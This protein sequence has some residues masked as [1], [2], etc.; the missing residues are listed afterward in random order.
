MEEVSMMMI[1]LP[2]FM[3]LVEVAHI[4]PILFGLLSLINME[5][6][7]LSPPFGFVLFT[8]KGVAPAGTTMGDVFRACVP[9]LILNLVAMLVIL[10]FPSIATW[11]PSKMTY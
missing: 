7:M 8:M 9:F 5:I 2:I 4:N 10:L 3:P 6:G 1:T 11:L